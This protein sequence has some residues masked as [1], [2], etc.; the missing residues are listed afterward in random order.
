MK[1]KS[2][3]RDNLMCCVVFFRTYKALSYN[4][5]QKKTSH[6]KSDHTFGPSLPSK[7]M[8]LSNCVSNKK[9]N[10]A[11]MADKQR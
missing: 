3:S 11:F 5:I 1:P 10:L 8:H 6:F 9:P 2:F 7:H 4:I